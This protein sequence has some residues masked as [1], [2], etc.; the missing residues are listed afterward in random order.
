MSDRPIPF[1]RV[2]VTGREAVYMRQVIEAS[3]LAGDGEFTRRCEE[4]LQRTVGCFRALLTHSGTAALEMAAMLADVKTGDE[5]IMPS[6]TFSSTAN[7][8]VLRGAVPVF[9]DIE[10]RTLNVDPA[11]IERAVT[12]RTRAIVPV[13]YAGVGCDMDAILDI[14]RRA[15]AV[16]IEDAAQ[17]LRSTWNGRPLGS[18][19]STAALSFHETKNITCGEGGCLL[20]NDPDL[21]QLA[22]IIRE[23]GTDRSR[24][25]RGEINK[26]SWVDLGSSYLPSE[27]TAA[28]LLAQLEASEE[29][30]ECRRAVWQRYHDALD[31][32][33][34]EGLLRRP[35]AGSENAHIYFVLLPSRE[36]RSVLI[37]ALKAQNISAV[38]HYVPLHTS[39]AGLRYGRAVGPL[40]VTENISERLLR[41]PLWADMT[42]EDVVRVTEAIGR[43]LR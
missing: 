42:G 32:L 17:A 10:P 18:F 40:P 28:F 37:G 6:F 7:A 43:A 20:I 27:L 26:Y 33:E 4:W 16:V 1:T 5:V 21:V 25:H 15:N 19:G 12:P 9:V 8:F 39:P 3:R 41:L 2:H 23:K 13:H 22:E 30:T 14:A 29:I 24:F 38:F 36:K 35:V 31:P 34:A 11:E